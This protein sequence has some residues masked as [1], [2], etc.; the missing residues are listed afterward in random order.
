MK[1]L[2]AQMALTG[3]IALLQL[4]GCDERG[5]A[6]RTSPELTQSLLSTPAAAPIALRAVDKNLESPTIATLSEPP[7]LEHPRLDPSKRD[8]GAS[9]AKPKAPLQARSV[10]TLP[11]HPRAQR[12]VVDPGRRSI[13]PAE[14]SLEPS[15]PSS[16]QAKQSLEPESP[17][18]ERP[19]LTPSAPALA[20][21]VIAS[22]P[23]VSS[24]PRMS[25]ATATSLGVGAVGLVAGFMGTELYAEDPSGG[26][27]VLS[28]LGAA[29]AGVG[30]TM[31]GVMMF[32]GDD[33]QSQPASE[34]RL[35]V[36]PGSMVLSGTF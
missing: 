12:D 17:K 4:T 8:R 19:Q 22:R 11:I 6:G 30:F 18:V 2:R 36:G 23:P 26:A 7:I 9:T 15:Q 20:P 27:V 29:A 14:P 13:K 32:R 25:F 35:A 5:S 31:A 21:I 1:P 34:V 10:T 3:L 33:A 24:G 16:E 28:L